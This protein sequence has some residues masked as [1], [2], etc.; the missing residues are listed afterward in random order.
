[1]RESAVISDRRRLATSLRQRVVSSSTPQVAHM[2]PTL[3]AALQT[4][5]SS[6]VLLA[7]GLFG[8]AWFTKRKLPLRPRTAA[9]V[10]AVP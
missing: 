4:E 10:T 2:I 5:S 8:L 3:V 6:L 1:M 9:G 7:L